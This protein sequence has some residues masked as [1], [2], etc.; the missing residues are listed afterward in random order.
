MDNIITAANVARNKRAGAYVGVTPMEVHQML[1]DKRDFVFL[2]VRTP[3]EYER[4]RLP[5]ATTVPLGSLRGRLGELPKDKPIITF[6]EI[7]LRGYEAA[8]ILRH[9]GFEDV[10]VMDGGVVMWP[11]E[12]VNGF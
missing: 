2:D 8:L 4:Q 10:R 11:Y 5:G 1:M 12:K 7:S 3:G 9:A 6:C